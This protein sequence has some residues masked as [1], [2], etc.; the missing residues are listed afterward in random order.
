MSAKNPPA[1]T[2]VYANMKWFNVG[3]QAASF[4]DLPEEFK[5]AHGL[6]KADK[7]KNASKILELVG[8]FVGAR[9]VLC[10]VSGWEELFADP[11]GDGFPEIEASTINVVGIDFA[12]EPLPSCKAEAYFDVPVTKDFAKVSDLDD[13]Q[14][15]NDT[16]TGAVIFYWNVPRSDSTEDLDFAVGDHSGGECVVGFKE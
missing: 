1:T 7:K 8:P 5:T 14:S 6:W 10:N 4:D 13:W 12:A 16:F 3:D 2:R 9:L 11:A 15:E